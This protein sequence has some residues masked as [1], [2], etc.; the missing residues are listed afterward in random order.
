MVSISA[1]A[2]RVLDLPA[3]FRPTKKHCAV[4][5]NGPGDARVVIVAFTPRAHD[6]RRDSERQLLVE[7][8]FRVPS[9]V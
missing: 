4:L 6:G 5:W 1:L 2:G 9:N 8:G 7:L 3:V